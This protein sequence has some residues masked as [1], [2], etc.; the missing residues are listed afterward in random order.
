V[1]D[2]PESPSALLERAATTLERLAEDAPQAP[3]RQAGDGDL[4]GYGPVPIVYTEYGDVDVQWAPGMVPWVRTMSP[5]VAS[6][7]VEWLRTT[8]RFM[9]FESGAVSSMDKL[10]HFLAKKYAGAIGFAKAV[11]GEP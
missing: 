11:L 5:S 9:H 10:P 6:P 2:T 7:L 4:L 8:A 1:T 3:W